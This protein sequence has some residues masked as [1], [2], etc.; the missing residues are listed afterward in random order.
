MFSE[1]V[2]M[3]MDLTVY[4]VF[5]IMFSPAGQPWDR[6]ASLGPSLGALFLSE[7]GGLVS[8]TLVEESL[9]LLKVTLRLLGLRSEFGSQCHL[10]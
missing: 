7:A 6:P 3:K 10:D 8:P 5:S 9:A 2:K 1:Y 4:V